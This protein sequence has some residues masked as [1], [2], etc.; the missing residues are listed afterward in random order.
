MNT[1]QIIAITLA[2]A[3]IIGYAAFGQ[4][5]QPPRTLVLDGQAVATVK[6]FSYH[7]D[8][9][10]F[11]IDTDQQLFECREGVIFSDRFEP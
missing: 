3:T 2:A 10:V 4:Q 8:Q 11:E 5:S 1:K 6:A 9:R 7:P